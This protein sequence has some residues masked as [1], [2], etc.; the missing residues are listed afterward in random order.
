[1]IAA[2][3]KSATGGLRTLILIQVPPETILLC[4]SEGSG[5]RAG[6]IEINGSYG[7]WLHTLE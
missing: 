1:M 3:E 5:P 2:I 4:L 7:I 6:S